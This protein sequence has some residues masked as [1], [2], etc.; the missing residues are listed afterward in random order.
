MYYSLITNDLI[1]LNDS[2]IELKFEL[3]YKLKGCNILCCMAHV[4][5]M[6]FHYKHNQG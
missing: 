1:I 4:K 5:L 2:K 3:M 6:S